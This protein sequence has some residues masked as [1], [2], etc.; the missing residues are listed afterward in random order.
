MSDADKKSFKER[1]R[2]VQA[3]PESERRHYFKTRLGA[4]VLV[5]WAIVYTPA[6]IAIKKYGF[7]IVEGS[8]AALMVAFSLAY[9]STQKMAKRKFGADWDKFG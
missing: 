2:A 1:W 9:W 3:T 7:P 6:M 5:Y 8:T 4:F